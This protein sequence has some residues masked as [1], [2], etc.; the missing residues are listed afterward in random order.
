MTQLEFRKYAEEGNVDMVKKGLTLKSIDPDKKGRSDGTALDKVINAPD[1]KTTHTKSQLEVA[2]ILLKNGSKISNH[3]FFTVALYG[4]LEMLK[5]LYKYS[6][7]RIDMTSG[8]SSGVQNGHV[9]TTAYILKH[10]TT[11]VINNRDLVMIIAA[12]A[13]WMKLEMFNTI[14]EY[15]TDP[16][17]DDNRHMLE[18]V[19]KAKESAIIDIIKSNDA[20][21]QKAVELEQ[22]QLYSETVKNVFLF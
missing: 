12:K 2:E 7:R 14:W 21:T 1:F 11:E 13:M 22:E 17:I 8:F 10:N 15:V 19:G 18:I 6:D 5:L 16:T 4:H 3:N 20:V 9:E